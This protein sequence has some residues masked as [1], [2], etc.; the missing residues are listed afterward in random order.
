MRGASAVYRDR[1]QPDSSHQVGR[2][3]L[4]RFQGVSREPIA[5]HAAGSGPGPRVGRPGCIHEG[6][7]GCAWGGAPDTYL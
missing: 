5:V 2:P 7:E 4:C 1:G 6:P 3:A